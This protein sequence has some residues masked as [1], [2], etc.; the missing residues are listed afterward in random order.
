MKSKRKNW[1]VAAKYS[2]CLNNLMDKTDSQI[3]RELQDNFPLC[4]RPY[5][6]IAEKLHISNEELWKRIRRLID[7]G[8]IRRI[9]ASLDSR[10]FGFCSTLA[11]IKVR[12]EQ[13]GQACEIIEK[14]SEI[15]HSYL[16]KD[17]FNIWFTIIASDQKK[18]K[19]IL[20][21]IR[22]SLSLEKSEILNLPA[23]RLFKL[24]ARFHNYIAA[25]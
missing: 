23:K 10:Q 16:R 21:H 6:I 9:G 24:D 11:A 15:T 2:K 25:P 1:N 20:E 13:I 8:V 4:E 22:T 12:P 3:L 5:E 14:F 7:D 18:I 19:D 17:E